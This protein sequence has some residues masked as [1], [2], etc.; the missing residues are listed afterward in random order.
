[1]IWAV[2]MSTVWAAASMAPNV[3]TIVSLAAGFGINR[4]GH[5]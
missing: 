2:M 1:M 4:A 3:A 5:G